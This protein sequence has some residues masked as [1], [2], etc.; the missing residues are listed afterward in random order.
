MA[1]AALRSRTTEQLRW[2]SRVTTRVFMD[3][4]LPRRLVSHHINSH[5]SF[6]K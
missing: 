2:S 1:S 5:T 6:E 3:R 4:P